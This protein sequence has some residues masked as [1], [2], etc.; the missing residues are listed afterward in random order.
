MR[1]EPL[2]ELKNAITVLESFVAH[3]SLDKNPK[4]ILSNM[5]AITNQVLDARDIIK[6]HANLI[7]TL[8]K[9]EN[10][11]HTTFAAKAIEVIKKYNQFVTAKI[12]HQE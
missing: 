2:R 1:D 6:S 3:K 8:L 11:E 4:S 5:K 9:Q 7:P 12:D 10:L